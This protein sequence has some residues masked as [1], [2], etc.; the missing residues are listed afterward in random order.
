M[1][2]KALAVEIPRS[3]QIANIRKRIVD[4]EAEI[5]HV[6][7]QLA[8]SRSD[9]GQLQAKKADLMEGILHGKESNAKA[10]ELAA[11][12]GQAEMVIGGMIEILGPKENLLA[13]LREDLNKLGAEQSR[14]EQAA[15]RKRKL[16]ELQAAVL[17]AGHSIAE[18]V[19]KLI[20]RDLPEYHAAQEALLGF[21]MTPAES[22]DAR[23]TIAEA[24][25]LWADASFLRRERELLR[26]GW[27]VRPNSTVISI[28]TIIPPARQ[29][30]EDAPGR[31]QGQGH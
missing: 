1:A 16:A 12:I 13:G 8:V 9:M 10:E 29:S 24:K 11:L 19:A 23:A 6:K 30:G 2:T 5:T 21:A 28:R 20:E 18:D 22:A 26:A 3:D 14:E 7:K 17:A 25:N 31:E 27:Q 4:L 15:N